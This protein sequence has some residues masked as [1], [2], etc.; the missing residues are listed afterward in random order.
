VAQNVSRSFRL[1][2]FTT[3][4]HS[5]VNVLSQLIAQK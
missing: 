5:F 1:V 4:T 2:P 3:F